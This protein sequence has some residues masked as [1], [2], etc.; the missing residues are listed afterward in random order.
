MPGLSGHISDLTSKKDIPD[1]SLKVEWTAVWAT[2][3][4]HVTPEPAELLSRTR[5]GWSL[6][7]LPHRSQKNPAATIETNQF[8]QAATR[9]V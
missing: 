1:G 9:L 7:T 3:R 6:I 8:L 4:Q 2:A 5:I